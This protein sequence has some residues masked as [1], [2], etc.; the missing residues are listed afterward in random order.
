MTE[1]GLD[2]A[3]RPLTRAE[4]QQASRMALVLAARVA[5]ARE[6]YHG[7]RLEHI[8]AEAGLSKG[9]VY[10]N[11]ASKAE[12]FLAVMDANIA[13]AQDA[14]QILIDDDRTPTDAESRDIVQQIRGF[15]LATLEFIA[16][17]VRDEALA[18]MLSSRI[19]RQLE[20][21]SGIAETAVRPDEP[22]QPAQ[23]GSLLAALE[24][25]AAILSLGSSAE[26]DRDLLA[27]GMSRLLTPA[28]DGR[29]DSLTPDDPSL[30]KY[31]AAPG[32]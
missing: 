29:L 18:P 32:A 23:L 28:D 2:R 25:G 9:A 3:R 5:F 22:L 8:A 7:A 17:A 15:A 24:Q 1:P 14:N 10:S 20:F 19:D 26:L 4:S 21:F 31:R 13:V 6:G 27:T 30:S 12:L 11:F 16:T